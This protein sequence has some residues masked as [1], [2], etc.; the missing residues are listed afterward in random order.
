MINAGEKK[1]N[2]SDVTTCP[3]K[4]GMKPKRLNAR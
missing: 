4:N 3:P 2:G 1:R